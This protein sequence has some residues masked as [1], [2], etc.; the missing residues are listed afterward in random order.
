M[1]ATLSTRGRSNRL[2]D[3]PHCLGL[4]LL[5]F[6][7]IRSSLRCRGEPEVSNTSSCANTLRCSLLHR[8]SNLKLL[9]YSSI[10]TLS[11]AH[12]QMR[13]AFREGHSSPALRIGGLN[14]E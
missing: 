12:T 6:L 8:Q 13:L 9:G 4:Q 14:Y 11:V 2:F 5:T 1:V 7:V 3:A 10:F